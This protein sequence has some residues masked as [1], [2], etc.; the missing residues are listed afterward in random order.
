MEVGTTIYLYKFN[1][2]NRELIWKCQLNGGLVSTQVFALDFRNGNLIWTFNGGSG[3]TGSVVANNGRFYFGSTVNSHFFC[4][5]A[6]GKRDGTTDL[7]WSIR[8][9]NKTEESVPAIYKGKA[10][11]LNSGGYLH[12]IE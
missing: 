8:M 4:V 1:K 10:Y 7:I 3:L 11:M 12:V 5:D 2:R 9:K 6:D